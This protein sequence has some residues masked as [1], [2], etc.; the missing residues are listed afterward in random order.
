MTEIEIAERT[1]ATLAD[2]RERA[3]LRVSEIAE[4]RKAIG[5]AVH[6][7]EDKAARAKL[8]KLNADDATMAG[9]LQSLDAA[10]REALERQPPT[11]RRSRRA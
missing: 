6:V 5:F 11:P 1:L 4:E 7:E 2:K 10:I 8:N 3:A 9:E